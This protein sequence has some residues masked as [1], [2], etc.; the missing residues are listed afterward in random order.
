ME[1][2]AHVA[3][4]T[5]QLCVAGGMRVRGE[6]VRQLGVGVSTCAL[7]IDEEERV[8]I[9]RH[10]VELQRELRFLSRR[11]CVNVTSHV[12]QR[13]AAPVHLDAV[14]V[15]VGGRRR[16]LVDRRRRRVPL[17]RHAQPHARAVVQRQQREE[18]R[19][20]ACV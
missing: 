11:Y 8:A 2:N 13:R 14:D 17:A 20:R 18:C 3:L 16:V 10:V 5:Q 12:L 4:A 19:R 6:R 7:Q 1:D 9:Y 15:D